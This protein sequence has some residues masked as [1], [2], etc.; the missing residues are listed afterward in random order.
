VKK[1]VKRLLGPV[2]PRIFMRFHCGLAAQGDR[3]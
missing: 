1:G 3:I 2:S